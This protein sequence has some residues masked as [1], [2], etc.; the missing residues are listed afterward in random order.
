MNWSSWRGCDLIRKI[1]YLHPILLQLKADQT[2]VD[3]TR[4]TYLS[5]ISK[6]S[7]DLRKPQSLLVSKDQARWRQQL[8]T[9]EAKHI[10]LGS[11]QLSRVT[12]TRTLTQNCCDAKP[13]SKFGLLVFSQWILNTNHSERG[14]STW[15]FWEDWFEQPSPSD[16]SLRSTERKIKSPNLDS[17]LAS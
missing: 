13:L 5:A 4:G 7:V 15:D 14:C 2:S 3:F 8:S 12:G 6:P 11:V 10:R 17:G 9:L 1:N 16:L